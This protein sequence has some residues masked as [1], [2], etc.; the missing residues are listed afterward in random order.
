MEDK[1]AP[2]KRVALGVFWSWMHIFA[3]VFLLSLLHTSS[4]SMRR[5]GFVLSTNETW[6]SMMDRQLASSV[7]QLVEQ[8]KLLVPDAAHSALDVLHTDTWYHTTVA[9]GVRFAVKVL[10]VLEGLIFFSM[11]VSSNH[12]GTF[13]AGISRV[14]RVLY[15]C[16][17]LWFYW[18]LAT[19]VVSVIV[20]LFLM[21]SITVFDT[22]YDPAYSAFQIEDYKHFLRFRLSPRGTMHV[23]VIGLR[24][25]HK[26]WE[27][28]PAHV[29]ES[30]AGGTRVWP[31]LRQFPSIWRPVPDAESKKDCSPR[32]IEQFSISPTPSSSRLR[33]PVAREAT[34]VD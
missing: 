31:F 33:S 34:C 32:L 26:V 21:V 25:V 30:S 9:T 24:K 20:A 12:I 11:R 28:D 10:D 2:W 23:F 8:A 1:L 6:D 16:H 27:R 3:A 4:I 15:Y 19:P 5:G 22:A 7:G 14:D 13:A 18:L 17:M 29:A